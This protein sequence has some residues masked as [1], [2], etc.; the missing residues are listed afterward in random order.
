MRLGNTITPLNRSER[1]QTKSTLQR[2]AD[3]HENDRQHRI[4]LNSFF[5][6]KILDVLLA[7][8]IPADNG[9]KGE[10]QKADGN[11]GATEATH[12]LRKG[13]LRQSNACSSAAKGVGRKDDQSRNCLE[14]IKCSVCLPEYLW[15]I[16][17]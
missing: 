9:G 12:Y 1:F 8:E 17:I 13:Q 10:E 3:D 5:T 6:E 15:N 2:R 7:E 16:N 11:E 4:D 14:T